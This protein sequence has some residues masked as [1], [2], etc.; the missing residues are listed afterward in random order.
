MQSDFRKNA[1]GHDPHNPNPEMPPG[2]GPITPKPPD[3][4]PLPDFDPL[5]SPV[6][7]PPGG[8]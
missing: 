4:P 6:V 5:P 8:T 1:G 2:P 3:L 7:A